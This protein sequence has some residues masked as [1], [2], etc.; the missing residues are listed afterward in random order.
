MT[1]QEV[2]EFENGANYPINRINCLNLDLRTSR[3]DDP[4]TQDEQLVAA[5]VVQTSVSGT[6]AYP[7]VPNGTLRQDCRYGAIVISG[8]E[9]MFTNTD[10]GQFYL[11]VDIHLTSPITRRFQRNQASPLVVTS[12]PTSQF[13]SGKTY[14]GVKPG[15]E[16]GSQNAYRKST[17]KVDPVSKVK[18]AASNSLFVGI[19]IDRI[20]GKLPTIRIT[21][22]RQM[23]II[24]QRSSLSLPR[25]EEY[26]KQFE[27][28]FDFVP[29][30]E[31][32]GFLINTDGEFTAVLDWTVSS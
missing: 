30:D 17:Q 3:S 1:S 16:S 23:T 26:N 21:A 2:E 19:D 7:A 14:L 31:G 24:S 20:E 10:L 8:Q 6:A 27:V 32:A 28:T 12:I 5:S 29:H 9:A 25:E 13:L 11:L 22:D 15:K 4:M 18:L